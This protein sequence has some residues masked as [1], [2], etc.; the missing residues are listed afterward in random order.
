M[1]TK[2]FPPKPEFSDELFQSD[3]KPAK[4]VKWESIPYTPTNLIHPSYV[5]TDS[6]Q[7]FTLDTAWDYK[8]GSWSRRYW[9]LSDFCPEG[10]KVKKAKEYF[11][12][13]FRNAKN[14]ANSL[15]SIA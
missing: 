1:I 5:S 2:L 12:R 15:L 6:M 10:R 11:F 4:K 9:V 13:S 3:R 14:A 7:R 8:N